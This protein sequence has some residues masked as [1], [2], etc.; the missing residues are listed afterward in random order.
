MINKLFYFIIFNTFIFASTQTV[1]IQN[2][3]LENENVS[4]N[5]SDIFTTHLTFEIDHYIEND[6]GSGKILRLKGKGL[7]ILNQGR[8]GDQ[9]VRINIFVPS[10]VSSEQKKVLLD[11][12]ELID[13]DTKFTRFK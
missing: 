2:A 5:S 6:I 7:P 3:D 11:F 8:F 12:E 4:V 13:I 1:K 9:L 10:S